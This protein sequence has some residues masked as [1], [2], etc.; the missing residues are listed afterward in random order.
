[1]NARLG[2]HGIWRPERSGYANTLAYG[3][4]ARNA[5]VSFAYHVVLAVD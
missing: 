5:I 2:G 1:M 4:V 3:S